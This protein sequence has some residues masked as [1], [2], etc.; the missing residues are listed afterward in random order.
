M[1]LL[2]NPTAFLWDRVIEFCRRGYEILEKCTT[3]LAA[4]FSYWLSEEKRP[5]LLMYVQARTCFS[6]C[7]FVWVYDKFDVL[8]VSL[9]YRPVIL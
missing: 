7:H 9:Y 2:T 6:D 5:L 1:L 8:A 3:H 4:L